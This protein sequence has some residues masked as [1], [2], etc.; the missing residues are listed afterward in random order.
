MQ[1]ATQ[2]A[3]FDQVGLD[4][5]KRNALFAPP[6]LRHQ[7]VLDVL[8]KLRMLF[9]VDDRRRAFAL[10]VGEELDAVDAGSFVC[11]L[12]PSLRS[13]PVRQLVMDGLRR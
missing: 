12:P 4:L 11:F 6:R 1:L 13:S 5:F 8:P 10:V 7:H 2:L 9:E 3:A